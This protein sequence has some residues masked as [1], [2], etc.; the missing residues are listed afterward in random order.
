MA[1]KKTKN[2]VSHKAKADVKEHV[3]KDDLLKKIIPKDSNAWLNAGI[4]VLIGLIV[5]VAIMYSAG[6][7]QEPVVID[8]SCGVEGS[9]TTLDVKNKVASYLNENLVVDETM[10]ALITDINEIDLGLFEMNFEIMQDEQLVGAGLIY[11]TENKLILPQAPAFNLNEELELIDDEPTT[12]E[13]Q[14]AEV[15]EAE[16]FVWGYCPGGISTLDVY[17]E[18]ANA[19]KDVASVKVVPFHDGHGAYETRQNKIMLAIQ[20]LYPEKTWDYM[21][22]FYE[23]VYPICTQ[24]S[25]VECT[26]IESTKL[27]EKVGIDAEAVMTLVDSN[28]DAMYQEAVLRAATLGIGTSPTLVVNGTSL[29]SQ[30]TRTPEGIKE[31]ICTGF[32]QAPSVCTVSLSEDTTAANGS[33]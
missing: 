17:A 6:L 16:L 15:A 3:K 7:V 9:L 22:D 8:D 13:V 26:N 21:L 10:N 4:F 5:G 29:G 19:L 14:K 30:F 23:D 18:T 32:I 20:E 24:E 31:I 1:K 27:M 11:S 28:G 33:C 25:T 2:H 12:T